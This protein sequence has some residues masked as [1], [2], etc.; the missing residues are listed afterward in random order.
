[1]R[2]YFEA[3]GI[4]LRDVASAIGVKPATISNMLADRDKIGK[5]RAK[6]L[7]EAYGFNYLFLL[8]GV[9]DL[10]GGPAPDPAPSYHQHAGVNNGTMQ[11]NNGCPDISELMDKIDKLTADLKAKEDENTWLRNLVDRLA[12]AESK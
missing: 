4:A 3:N 2:Q 5:I 12:P 6:R 11:Q 7:N 9:G 8:T 1:M 10:F